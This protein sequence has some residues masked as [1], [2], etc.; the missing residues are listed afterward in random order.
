[1]VRTLLGLVVAGVVVS[2]G[3]A[4][5]GRHGLQVRAPRLPPR[6]VRRG[7]GAALVDRVSSRRRR[8]DHRT[9]GTA[10]HRQERQAAAAAV[11][12]VPKVA[13]TS[14]GG[15]LEVMPHPNFASNR[16]L[17]LSYSKLK[18]DGSQ[19]TSALA[20]GRFE[21]DQLTDVQPLFESISSG[22]Q[23]LRRQDRVR[24]ERLPVSHA[25]RSTG[26]AGRQ[27]RSAPGA[28]SV[29]PPRQDHP[30]A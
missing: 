6:A 14:Q 17:Y 29:E 25:R 21:N 11:E 13:V 23:S 26:S 3:D 8:A 28:G 10:A 4:R 24:Q 27:P 16:M 9:A 12:G 20:R 19:P 15:L 18:A 30:S 22:A 5:L 1:M 2:S 7:A